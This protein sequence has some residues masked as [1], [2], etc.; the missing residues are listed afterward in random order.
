MLPHLANF[1]NPCKFEGLI[2][3]QRSPFATCE[4]LASFNMADLQTKWWEADSADSQ[5]KSSQSVREKTRGPPKGGV[6]GGRG[7]GQTKFLQKKTGIFVKT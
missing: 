6:E 1:Y 2:A 4:I 7:E 3:T 5:S